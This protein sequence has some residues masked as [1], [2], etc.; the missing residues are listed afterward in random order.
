LASGSRRFASLVQDFI[1]AKDMGRE[2][3]LGRMVALVGDAEMDEGN[4]YEVLQ[5]GWKNDLRNTLVDHRLQPP[6]ARRDR[7][8]GAVRTDREDLR[9][10]RLGR[11]AGE[12]RR[13]Q[14]AAFAEPGGDRLRDWIDACP[15]AEYSAL[16]YMGGAVWRTRLMDDLGDQGDVTALI[17]RRSDANWPR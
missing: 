15:N 12:I 6:V 11:G 7:A 17:D 8:R 9:R 2:V 5:E 1:A 13:L 3:P 14:R 4:V 10:L 16:T